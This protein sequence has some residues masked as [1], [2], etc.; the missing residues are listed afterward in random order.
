M[1][2]KD[3]NSIGSV[4]RYEENKKARDRLV[5]DSEGNAVAKLT[6]SRKMH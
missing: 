6:S 4:E 3:G 1:L 5:V 2:T